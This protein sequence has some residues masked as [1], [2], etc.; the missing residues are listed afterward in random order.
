MSDQVYVGTIAVK[1]ASA[2]SMLERAK[3]DRYA[4]EHRAIQEW[5][6]LSEINTQFK[7]I[8]ITALD[9]GCGKDA[10]WGTALSDQLGSKDT[11]CGMDINEDAGI[12]QGM[13]QCFVADYL[14]ADI[15]KSHY[16]LLFGNPPFNIANQW[17]QKSFDIVNK[18]LGRVSFLFPITLAATQKR[19]ELYRTYPISRML[20]YSKRIS[21]DGYNGGTYPAREYAQFEWWF[22]NGVCLTPQDLAKT[23]DIEPIDYL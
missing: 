10:R 6:G 20:I 16:N 1:I 12:E 14:T 2:L 15:A 13:I 9:T 3:N 23:Y 5:L 19:R 17:L 8:S 4:T 7:R 11:V 21:F 18:D 22:Q